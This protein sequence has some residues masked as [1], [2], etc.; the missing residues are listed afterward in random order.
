MATYTIWFQLTRPEEITDANLASVTV[1]A[2]SFEEAC[3]IYKESHKDDRHDWYGG[4][5][6]GHDANR[7][8]FETYEEALEYSVRKIPLPEYIWLQRD[9]GL[10]WVMTEYLK[11]SKAMLDRQRASGFTGIIDL[12]FYCQL[13][14]KYLSYTHIYTNA[15]L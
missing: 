6:Y 10:E 14:K 2:N 13:A 8:M 12:E 3:K 11:D 15:S 7:K 4:V 9:K 5:F 1:I